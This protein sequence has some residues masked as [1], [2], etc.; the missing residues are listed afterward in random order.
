MKGYDNGSNI[1]EKY[2]GVQTRLNKQNIV[3]SNQNAMEEFVGASSCSKATL[4][5]KLYNLYSAVSQR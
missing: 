1:K 4:F 3:V 2:R 5:L